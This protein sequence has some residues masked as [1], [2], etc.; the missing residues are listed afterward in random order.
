MLTMGSLF[1][2]I[3]GWQIAAERYGI[4]PVWSSEIEPFCRYITSRQ[5]P[6]TRQLGDITK[7]NTDKIAVPDILCAGSPCQDLSVAGK[8]RGLDGKRSG[9]FREAIRIARALRKRGGARYFVW[10]N[11]PG[12]F[13]SNHGNDFR[14]V[15]EEICE[16]DVPMPES[17][18]WAAAGVVRSAVCN[19]C[20]RV[21][22]AQFF[23]VPQY[24]R[25]IFLVADYGKTSRCADKIL[26]E[27]SRLQGNPAQGRTETDRAAA[28]AEAG[29]ADPD[30]Y[31]I[32]GNI[33]NRKPKNG[34]NGRGYKLNTCYTLNTID[35]HAI[36]GPILASGG[37]IVGTRCA[38]C[39]TKQ[40]LGNQEVRSGN[41][42]IIE[43]G[44]HGLTVRRLTPLECE[45]LQG[46]PEGWTQGGAE[47]DRLQ[48]LGNGMAQPCADFVMAGIAHYAMLAEA[49]GT[50]RQ[51]AGV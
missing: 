31:A 10:E 41:Y 34:G 45:R 24:R 43:K 36:A 3:G 13:S 21:L 40:W 44:R 29:S 37:E 11:V 25:R 51:E 16:T 38:N 46:L 28:P 7:I 27:Y 26:L 18:K 17:H 49:A 9:L 23:G 50:L 32:A 1:D 20:W 48:A 39:G 5:F 19:V 6:M 30:Y 8:R 22:D 15:L 14:A 2:G 35:H 47:K 42:H 33:I 12:A 4:K